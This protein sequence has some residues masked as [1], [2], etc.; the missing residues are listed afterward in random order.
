MKNQSLRCLL[1]S[2]LLILMQMNLMAQEQQPNLTKKGKTLKNTVRFNVTNPLIFGERSLVFG[3]ERLTGK[4][5]SF[6]INIGEASLPNL[7]SV[8]A[9][10]SLVQI[11][12]N[13]TSTGFHISG[14][15]R[16]YL[17]KENK[18]NA[19]RG[20]YL[21]PYLAYNGFER[22]NNW[23]LNTPNFSGELNTV[24]NFDIMLAGVE[25]GYQFVLW[26]RLAIDCIFI[27]PGL[28]YYHTSVSIDEPIVKQDESVVLGDLHD[29]LS[30]KIPGFNSIINKGEFENSGSTN[31]TSFGYRF[32]VHLGFRF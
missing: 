14:D 5:Q 29:A 19:P 13:S 24:L 26:N 32:I 18:F 12:R 27:G 11:N 2:A 10:N 21:G 7:L 4:H 25:L 9:D 22:K 30:G 31:T 8:N 6:S 15:Y 28:A 23:T 3:Y 16:F 17:Q 20:I 1:F